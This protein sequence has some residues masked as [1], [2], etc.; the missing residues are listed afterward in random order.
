MGPFRA[1]RGQSIQIGALLLFAILIVSLSLYQV[2]AV[3]SQNER[4]EF[5]HNERVQDRIGD[6]RNSM[7]DTAATGSGRAVSVSLGPQYPGRGIFIN[8]APPSG[9][10]RTVGTDS[11]DVA[12]RVANAEATNAET[13]DVW[14]GSYTP[15]DPGDVGYFPTGSVVY[16]P[17]YNYYDNAPTTRVDSSV[18][19]NEFPNG[20]VTTLTRQSLVDGR[21]ITLVAVAG[22][23]SESESG[24][25]SVDVN[26]VSA[27]SREVAVRNASGERVNVTVPTLLSEE[28]WLDLLDGQLNQ[29][30]SSCDG[31]DPS[32]NE[33]T[34]DAAYVT[35]C[36][37]TDGGEFSTLTLTMEQGA[38]YTLRLGRVGVGN[39][40]GDVPASYITAPGSDTVSVPAG[41]Q[42]T[43][44]A[45][46]RDRYDNPVSGEQVTASVTDG[47]LDLATERSDES[48]RARFVYTAPSTAGTE[49]VTATI[50]GGGTDATEVT[51][52]VNVQTNGG[53]GGS[54]S[55]LDVEWRN[56]SKYDDG[57]GTTDCGIENCTLFRGVNSDLTVATNTTDRE[58]GQPIS[59]VTVE[60][61]VNNTS[62]ATVSPSQDTTNATGISTTTLSTS[63]TGVVKVYATI[64]GDTDTY[65]VNV[66]RQNTPP[67]ASFT[68]NDST[69]SVGQTVEFDASGSSDSDGS[70]ANY[71]WDFGDGTTGSGETTTHSYGS[72]GTYTVT[73]TVTDDDGA[74]D[75][76]TETVTVSAAGSDSGP[77]SVSAVNVEGAP[78]NYSEAGSASSRNVTVLFNQTMDTGTDPT[79]DVTDVSASDVGGDGWVND[80]AYVDMVNIEQNS[81][82]VTATVEVSDAQDTDGNTM[83]PNP[84]S[85]TFVVDTQRPGQVQ[86][87]RTPI[88]ANASNASAVGIDV[89]NPG[90][91]Y[92]DET[93]EV[94]VEGP[95]GTR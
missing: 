76:A 59:G 4:V 29:D 38:T 74:T 52:T 21:R 56:A 95:A 64:G 47:S 81:E 22:N 82:D 1:E 26:P 20:A 68:V 94:T 80:T 83:T 87:I 92:G 55:V 79:V 5:K 15:T 2:T 91:V 58:S 50:D 44:T 53:G 17:A 54:S 10:L 28:E 31:T 93:V 69:P 57:G 70:I 78:V 9:T 8:P 84:D 37:Y 12:A 77:P 19:Y 13:R 7:Q 42:V 43:L 75:T 85:R 33:D 63:T 39:V 14:N 90:T 72:A 36:N 24:S 35:A 62:V 86:S 88:V 30:V 34:T 48:G 27:P 60:Y 51:F 46:V 11:A 16:E 73:L 89:Q 23:Y 61:A 65:V 41:E 6:L 3:P 49:T 45:E 32:T 40:N 25:A 71:D 18:A 67:T 66:T